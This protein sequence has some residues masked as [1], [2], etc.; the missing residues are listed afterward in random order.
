MKTIY[1]KDKDVKIGT[2]WLPDRKR[3]V[4]YIQKG[5]SVTVCASFQSEER[6]K[7]FMETLIRA[8]GAQGKESEDE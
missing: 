3:P 1:W 4:L 5:T 8:V 6:A 2:M 7:L